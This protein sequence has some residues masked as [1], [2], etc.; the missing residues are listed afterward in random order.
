MASLIVCVVCVSVHTYTHEHIQELRNIFTIW[1]SLSGADIC[2]YRE[3]YTYT[4]IQTYQNCSHPLD[5][6]FWGEDAASSRDCMH[7]CVYLCMHECT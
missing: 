2:T 6:A 4:H 1:I 3:M 7:V 5:V